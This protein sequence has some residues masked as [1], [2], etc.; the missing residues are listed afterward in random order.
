VES[1]SAARRSAV[2][3]LIREISVDVAKRVIDKYCTVRQAR[4]VKVIGSNPI[5]AT[6]IDTKN[7]ATSMDCWV[8][9][10]EVEPSP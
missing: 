3:D 9:V 7:P 8:F 10:S 4:N 2:I 6:K 5:P 1:E